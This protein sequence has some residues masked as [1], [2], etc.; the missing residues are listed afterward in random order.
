M[1]GLAKL[2]IAPDCGSGG[3][4]FDS[5]ISP[6]KNETPTLVVGVL[7]LSSDL[8]ERTAA[9]NAPW[10]DNQAKRVCKLACKCA[11]ADCSASASPFGEARHAVPKPKALQLA[12]SII[13]S[14]FALSIHSFLLPFFL[15]FLALF[16]TPS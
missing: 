1:V 6:H 8:W 4:G 7:F 9:R 13:I 11:S 2:V 10:F 15:L 12:R 5:H 14:P 3:R 16:F